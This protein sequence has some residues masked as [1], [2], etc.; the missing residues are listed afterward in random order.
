ML[1]LS[2][3]FGASGFL[4]AKKARKVFITKKAANG[5]FARKG[6]AYSMANADTKF[7]AKTEGDARYLAA[8][9]S[10]Q[11][12]VPPQAWVSK[13]G[14]KPGASVLYEPG[15]SG[16]H[17]EGTGQVFL[18]GVTLPST[19]QG[20]TVR[21]DGFELCYDAGSLAVLSDVFLGT[22]FATASESGVQIRIEDGVDRTDTACRT[23]SA[24]NPIS[25]SPTQGV[26]VGV[27][28]DYPGSP[29]EVGILRLTLT[30]ST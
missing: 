7:I 20:R 3:A 18:A 26:V 24:G 15:S 22:T 27:H 5:R 29:N 25:L 17:S 13:D 4:T 16:L 23:Y 8:A 30:L 6:D 2:P 9:G 19:L 12:Q 21:I 1:A 10:T 28:A 14:N 11:L